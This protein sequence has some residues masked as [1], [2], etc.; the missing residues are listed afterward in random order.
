MR[1]VLTDLC[2]RAAVMG[3]ADSLCALN[4]VVTEVGGL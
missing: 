4:C 1:M 3:D 2:E